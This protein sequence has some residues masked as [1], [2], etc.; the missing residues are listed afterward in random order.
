MIPAT[1]VQGHRVASGLNGNPRFPGG[2]LRMQ[3]PF[4]AALGLDLSA[5]YPGTLNVSIAP[6]SYRGVKPRHMFRALKW[7]PE[8][9]AEDFSFFDVTVHREDAEPVRGLI[10]HPH[11]ETKP[12]HF[13]KPDVLELLLPWTEGLGY[14]TKIR[15]EVP[16]E[17]MMF[18][19]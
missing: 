12:V 10:Y 1:I 3:L 4:F 19:P 11:P 15:L 17:Q 16:E 2:T 7:H 13:Q 9:P 8:D 18:G 14:G 6:L 5:F